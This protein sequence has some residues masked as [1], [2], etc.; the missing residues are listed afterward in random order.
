M[1]ILYS[2]GCNSRQPKIVHSKRISLLTACWKSLLS[3]LIVWAVVILPHNI[4]IKILYPVLNIPQGIHI[5]CRVTNR[6]QSVCQSPVWRSMV[7]IGPFSWSMAPERSSPSRGYI[8]HS[9]LC[10]HISNLS[11]ITRYNLVVVHFCWCQDIVNI[12]VDTF[13]RCERQEYTAEQRTS[14]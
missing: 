6:T 4:T 2:I 5:I 1:Q 12:L 3:L 14:D 9:G 11:R 8:R 13:R 10:R 7:T